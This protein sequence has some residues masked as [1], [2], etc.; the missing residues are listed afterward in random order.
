M[1]ACR[2]N[3]SSSMT[4][5]HFLRFFTFLTFDSKLSCG[6]KVAWHMFMCV[7][8][9]NHQSSSRH[10]LDLHENV[11]AGGEGDTDEDEEE[12]GD[13]EVQDQQVRCVLHLRVRHHLLQGGGGEKAKTNCELA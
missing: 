6:G 12:V 11:V 5:G 1:P 3:T 13:G 4:S 9:D 10:N 8:R 7:C 2:Y